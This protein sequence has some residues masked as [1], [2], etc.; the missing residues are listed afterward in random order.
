MNDD[1]AQKI[2]FWKNNRLDQRFT[3]TIDELGERFRAYNQA[4]DNLI[5][6][7]SLYRVI[8]LFIADTE[9][10]GLGAVSNTEDDEQ[11]RLI[12]STCCHAIFE[13]GREH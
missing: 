2:E 6:R 10:G 12:W 1:K 8:A 7:T 9:H 5:T 13:T 3:L 11:Q 4:R